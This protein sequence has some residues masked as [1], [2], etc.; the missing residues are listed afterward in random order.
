MQIV[1]AQNK[2]LYQQPLNP[3]SSS[4]HTNKVDYPFIHIFF[5]LNNTHASSYYP[6]ALSELEVIFTEHHEWS[7]LEFV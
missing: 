2:D 7:S 3:K 5:L 4:L 1:A 6:P